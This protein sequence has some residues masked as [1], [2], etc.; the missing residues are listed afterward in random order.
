[1][2][3][4]DI[5]DPIPTIADEPMTRPSGIRS[6]APKVAPIP[7]EIKAMVMR[8]LETG[9]GEVGVRR[10][11]SD[12]TVIGNQCEI[13]PGGKTP[14]VSV[15]RVA[16][17][18]GE[19]TSS[20]GIC[21]VPKLEEG[22]ALEETDREPGSKKIMHTVNQRISDANYIAVVYHSNNRDGNKVILKSTLEV[23]AREPRVVIDFIESARRQ[24]GSIYKPFSGSEES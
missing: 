23:Y 21:R 2:K 5:R 22:S 10:I 17:T 12:H 16:F 19:V 1:M 9:N 24:K 13:M 6:L 11:I 3:P 18:D 15:T 7:E 8:A 14:I 20:S 4:N